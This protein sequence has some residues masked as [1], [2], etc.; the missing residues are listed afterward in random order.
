MSD[1][2]AAVRTRVV[3]A[4]DQRRVWAEDG[5]KSPSARLARDVGMDPETARVEVRRARKLRRMPHVAA[6]LADGELSLDKADLLAR[7]CTRPLQPMFERDEAFLVEQVCGL[8]FVPARKAVEYWKSCARDQ[9][10]GSYD[11]KQVQSRHAN[12]DRTFN[13]GIHV[14]AWLPAVAGTIAHDEWHRLERQLFEA[15]LA[16]ARLE[17]GDDALSHL[18]RAG[19]QRMADALVVMARRPARAGGRRAGG[20][21][22]V[23]G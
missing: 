12:C 6:A 19:A 5:S 20:R 2:L 15:D 8:R 10:P 3:S 14:S 1:R 21:P 9:V 11:D 4:W 13:G 16:A 23:R 18:R 17:H 22:P 7:G